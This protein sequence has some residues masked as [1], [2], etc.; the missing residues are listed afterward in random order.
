MKNSSMI[1][2]AWFVWDKSY[3]GETTLSWIYEKEGGRGIEVPN[4]CIKCAKKGKL[5]KISKVLDL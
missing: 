1:A 2:Y 5:S 3:K 4:Y